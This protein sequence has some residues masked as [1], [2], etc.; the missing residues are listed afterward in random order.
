MPGVDNPRSSWPTWDE[1]LLIYFGGSDR[2]RQRTKAVWQEQAKQA[3]VC[4][5]WSAVV[6]HQPVESQ[7]VMLYAAR[8]GKQ[9]AYSAALARRHFE[10][11]Q[12]ASFRTTVLDAAEEA[13]LERTTVESFLN[14]EEL[15]KEVWE[16][17][18]SLTQEKRINSIPLFVFNVHGLTAGGPFREEGERCWS[19]NG[20]QAPEAFLE[21]FREMLAAAEA[22]EKRSL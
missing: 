16:S 11:G 6:Q 22:A 2:V 5:K 10:E 1:N 17:F 15:E 14:T 8:F 20:A 19:V 13:G 4:L 9:E 21:V 3:G 7:R 12:S 18:R